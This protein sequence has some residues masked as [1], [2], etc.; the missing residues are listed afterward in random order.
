MKK[1]KHKQASP[2][3]ENHKKKMTII[4]PIDEKEITITSK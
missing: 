1:R 2:I 4:R 3:D